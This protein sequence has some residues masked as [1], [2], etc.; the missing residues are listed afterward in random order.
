VQEEI[1]FVLDRPF[2]FVVQS[3]NM[4]LFTGIVNNP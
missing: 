2:L 3:D 4:P 1:D